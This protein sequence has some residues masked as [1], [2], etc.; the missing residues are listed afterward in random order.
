MVEDRLKRSKLQPKV[1]P[2]PA[3]VPAAAVE[4]TPVLRCAKLP[5]AMALGLQDAADGR[6]LRAIGR[7]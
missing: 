3:A 7:A 4:A 6:R 1:Q 5:F 2:Q